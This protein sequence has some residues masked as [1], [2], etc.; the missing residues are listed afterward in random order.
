MINHLQSY[1]IESEL[2][3]TLKMILNAFSKDLSTQQI[4]ITQH[5]HYISLL[6]IHLLISIIMST[7]TI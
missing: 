5:M 3:H 1:Y 7:L 4:L 2:Q 6:K